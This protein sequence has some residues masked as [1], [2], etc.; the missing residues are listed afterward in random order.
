MKLNIEKIEPNA[1]YIISPIGY[2]EHWTESTQIE[3]ADSVTNHDNIPDS[4]LFLIL[5][6]RIDKVTDSE[7]IEKM[8]K[9][10]RESI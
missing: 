2:D 3:I 8:M 10:V 4:A 5:P 7:K 9:I 1:L 6:H